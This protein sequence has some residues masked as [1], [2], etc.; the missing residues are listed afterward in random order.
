MRTLCQNGDTYNFLLDDFL[1][2]NDEHLRNGKKLETLVSHC[3]G[4][5]MVHFELD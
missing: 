2:L 5:G 4:F 3:F 1:F